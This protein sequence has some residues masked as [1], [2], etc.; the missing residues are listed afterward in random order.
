LDLKEAGA[1]DPNEH[2]Y[3]IHK[4][5]MILR[6]IKRLTQTYSP[7]IDVGSG[8]GFFAQ[9]VRKSFGSAKVTCVDPNY[10]EMQIGY[11]DGIEYQTEPPLQGGS[12]YLFID[13]L[14]HV[15]EPEALLSNYAVN[16]N[17]GAVFVLTVPAFMSLWSP[18][19]VYLGHF[20]R[21]TLS[22]L[23][24]LA[25]KCKMEVLEAKYLFAPIFPLVFAYRKIFKYRRPS[26]D[27]KS[28]SV[29]TN[30]ILVL[31]LKIDLITKHNRVFG[32]SAFVV[33]RTLKDD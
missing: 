30:L 28:A 24:T 16:S 22:E 3:Y 7:V 12:L 23:E 11:R 26:S 33:A 17:P 14:E 21:Y 27:L 5:R 29:L 18:H 8:S 9:Q 10:D 2:W 25:R 13:V 31:L 20:K 32:T 19:D 6:S 15:E 1:G 4:S